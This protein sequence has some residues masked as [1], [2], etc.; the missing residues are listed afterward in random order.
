MTFAQKVRAY[1]SVAHRFVNQLVKQPLEACQYRRGGMRAT[2]IFAAA[3]RSAPPVFFV[4]EQPLELGRRLLPPPDTPVERLAAQQR[5]SVDKRY[6]RYTAGPR[7]KESV[8]HSLVERGIDEHACT[9]KIRLDA[10]KRKETGKLDVGERRCRV[11]YPLET[12]IGT[13]VAACAADHDEAPPRKTPGQLEKKLGSFVVA[14]THARDPQHT[15]SGVRGYAGRQ[16][17]TTGN[18]SRFTTVICA[19]GLLLRR[20][21]HYNPIDAFEALLEQPGVAKI[22]ERLGPS[23]TGQVFGAT[24]Q[25]CGRGEV[26]AGCNGSGLSRR[27]ASATVRSRRLSVSSSLGILAR[28]TQITGLPGALTVHRSDRQPQEDLLR[29]RCEVAAGDAGDQKAHQSGRGPLVESAQAGAQDRIDAQRAKT[30]EDVDEVGANENQ[31]GYPHVEDD[32]QV[33]VVSLR[34]PRNTDPDSRA[35]GLGP[36]NRPETVA[37]NGAAQHVG[38]EGQPDPFDAPGADGGESASEPP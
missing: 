33:G 23:N 21:L 13:G 30:L 31:A 28:G 10:G 15:V 6:C 36:E 3:R 4:G 22:T 29:S 12:G 37:V 2:E 14:F 17:V 11:A 38:Q 26:P 24:K 9:V 5:T 27:R 16:L 1:S 8:R 20:V 25:I 32:L 34:H 35:H 7:L 18:R 19:A